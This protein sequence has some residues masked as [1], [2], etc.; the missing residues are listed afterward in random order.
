[1]WLLRMVLAPSNRLLRRLEL[2]Y[3]ILFVGMR[4]EV[5][6]DWGVYLKYFNEMG[7]VPLSEFFSFYYITIDIGYYVLGALIYQLGGSIHIANLAYAFVS[8]IGLYIFSKQFKNRDYVFLLYYP[9]VIVI[10]A[11]GYTRQSVAVSLILISLVIVHSKFKSVMVSLLAL[12][13]HKSVLLLN[14]FHIRS[15]KSLILFLFFSIGMLV[16]FN[17]TFNTLHTNYIKSG[18]A[19][20]GFYYRLAL[21]SPLLL[22][23][24][25]SRRTRVFLKTNNP[26]EVSYF[27]NTFILFILILG[28][29]TLSTNVADRFLI[30]LMIF[31]FPYVIHLIAVQ[32]KSDHAFYVFLLWSYNVGS[33]LVWFLTANNAESWLPYQFF[34]VTYFD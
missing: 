33:L 24:A 12:T 1:M 22:I 16:I 34:L 7:K 9:Y 10:F 2:C 3:L 5:G 6:G 11:M 14:I 17:D 23:F 19:S 29:S 20:A 21:L 13:F 4:H 32:G 25:L 18:K 28:L 30:V 15:I 26:I 27:Y 31:I 8:I